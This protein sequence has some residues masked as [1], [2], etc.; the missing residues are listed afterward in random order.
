M[1]KKFLEKFLFQPDKAFLV[2]V[3]RE[4]FL[5]DDHGRIVPIAKKVLNHLSISERFGYELSAC[6]LEDRVGPCRLDC[7]KTELEKNEAK[8][9]RA[10]IDLGFSRRF[11]EVAPDNMPLDVYPDPTGRYQEIVKDMPHDILLAAC[12][13]TGIHV[14]IGMPDHMT[15]LRV[16]N[17]AVQ[18]TEWLCEIGNGSGGKRLE[19]YKTMAPKFNPLLYNS[20]EDFYNVAIAEGF[21]YDLRKCWHLIRLSRHGT[22]EFRMFGS[23]HDLDKITSWAKEC[24][25][26]CLRGE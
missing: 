5:A 17:K 21:A 18:Y 6:Q 19:I 15:A 16:Y 2:G 8:V 7:V 13:V 9:R 1:L 20:W 10:E 14:H 4:C 26:I 23:T 12:R 25:G 24:H 22:I 11:T 3:E